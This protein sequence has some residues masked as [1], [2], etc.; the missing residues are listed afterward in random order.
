MEYHKRFDPIYSDAHN[1]IRALGP[2]SYFNAYMAQPKQQLDTFKAWAGGRWGWA[3]QG[4]RSM[5]RP[6]VATWCRRPPARPPSAASPTAR[7]QARPGVATSAPHSAIIAPQGGRAD[8]DASHSQYFCCSRPVAV[9]L[10]PPT[11]RAGKS[12]DISYYLNSHHI[13][14]HNWSIQHMARPVKVSQ[15]PN[16]AFR[17]RPEPPAQRA[18]R[19]P[20]AA[21]AAGAPP[22][23]VAMSCTGVAEAKLGRPCEDTITL[24]TQWRNDADQSLGTALYTS[25]WITPK[26]RRCGC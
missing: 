26:A 6:A 14:I 16:P 9:P 23:V 25:S 19:T 2:F 17:R 22:Q 8:Q 4:S 11:R 7:A 24:M 1:R 3:Q 20:H 5:T 18:Q 15:P 12:S 21:E 10:P 13:D